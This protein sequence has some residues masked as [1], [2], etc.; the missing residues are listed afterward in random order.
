MNLYHVFKQFLNFKKIVFQ[1]VGQHLASTGMFF[2]RTKIWPRN[3]GK[4]QRSWLAS[5]ILLLEKLTL[6]YFFMLKK[7]CLLNFHHVSV[8]DKNEDA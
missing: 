3:S 1:T 2:L 4:S 6:K 7:E 5:R 8:A